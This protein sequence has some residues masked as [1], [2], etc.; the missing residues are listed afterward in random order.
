MKFCVLMLF[1][2]LCVLCVSS[3]VIAGEQ[4]VLMSFDNSGHHVRHIVMSQSRRSMQSTVKDNAASHIEHSDIEAL[5]SRLRPGFALL[6]W[7]NNAGHSNVQTKVPDPRVSHAPAHINGSGKSRLGKREGAWLV[8]GP[9]SATSVNILLP[10]N[11]SLGLGFEQW[12]VSL[13]TQ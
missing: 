6:V 9:D 10:A 11:P 12:E 7:K 2:A 8:V 1:R 5:I 4:R 13:V 3:I